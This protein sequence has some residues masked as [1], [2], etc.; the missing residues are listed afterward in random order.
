VSEDQQSSS[1]RSNGPAGELPPEFDELP[2]EQETENRPSVAAAAEK[3]VKFGPMRRDPKAELVPTRKRLV[4]LSVRNNPVA[5]WYVRT[6]TNR[7]HHGVLPIF[8]DKSG[9]DSLYLV[10]ESVQYL[11]GNRVRNNHCLTVTKQGSPFLWCSPLEQADGEWNSWHS[12]AYDMKEIAAETWIKVQSNKQIAGFEPHEIAPHLAADE[13][14]FPDNL[15]WVDIIALAFRRRLIEK[16][17]HPIIR[18][19]LEG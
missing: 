4:N 14:K 18:R 12:S 2:E 7:E 15:K 16:E 17:N 5:D 6:S 11:L 13:P 8:R 9:D 10:D 3:F 1:V 19:I